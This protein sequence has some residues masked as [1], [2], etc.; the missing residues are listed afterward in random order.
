MMPAVEPTGTP[1]A[2]RALVPERLLEEGEVV[3]LAVKPSGW[4]VPLVSWPALLVAA[5]VAAVTYLAEGILGSSL[6]V[7]AR[8]VGLLCVAFAC[9]RLVAAALQWAGRLYVL[10]NLRLIRV[11]GVFGTDVFQCP[12][13]A[14]RA[15]QLTAGVAE[16]SLGV[17][18]LVFTIDASREGSA[19]WVH[20]SHP[21]EVQRIVNEAIHRRR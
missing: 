10:T 3:I 14:V 17:G 6:P 16:R 8:L 15:A 2:E 13:K 21:A 1:T 18:T 20:I 7:Q 11:R 19:A 9:L 12:L 5:I 4:F